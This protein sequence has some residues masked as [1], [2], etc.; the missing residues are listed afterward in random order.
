MDTNALPHYETSDNP[1][2]CCPRFN[3]AGWGGQALHF[4]DKRFLRATTRSLFHIPLNMGTVY[5]RAMAAIQAANAF[6]TEG[7]IVLSHDESA[8]RGEHLFAISKAVPGYENVMLSGDFLT[9]V[10]EG[11]FR[12]APKWLK[13]LKARAERE[14]E[15]LKDSYYFYTTCPK[16]AAVYGKNYVVGLARI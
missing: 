11:P 8:W 7:H 10:F 9:E 14:G 2:G 3:P 1:T 12:D 16:C 5:P 13:H 15:A 4:R 6:D